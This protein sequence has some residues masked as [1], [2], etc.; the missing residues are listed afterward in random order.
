MISISANNTLTREVADNTIHDLCAQG[1][2]GR[3]LP[4]VSSLSSKFPGVHPE[5]TE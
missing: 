3:I 4:L 2:T 1:N 5:Q